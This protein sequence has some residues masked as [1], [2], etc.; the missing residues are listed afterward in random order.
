MPPKALAGP[1]GYVYGRRRR[2]VKR[3]N[4]LPIRSMGR[5]IKF[6]QR[7]FNFT[8]C[9]DKEFLYVYPDGA[10]GIDLGKAYK[11]QLN[12]LPNYDEFTKLFDYYRIKCV[13]MKF[14]PVT[15]QTMVNGPN[16]DTNSNWCPIVYTCI[17]TN[18]NNTPIDETEILQEKTCK[19]FP[20]T[21]F[22]TFKIYPKSQTPVYRDGISN[23][24]SS[25]KTNTWIDTDNADVPYYGFKVYVAANGNYATT[26]TVR[27]ICKYYLQVKDPK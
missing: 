24:Y 18:D 5:L 15:V 23:A 11:F 27:V 3:V 26:F 25:S 21:S 13:V 1:K 17:D 22:K 9:C 14:I 10:P 7:V 2:R 12:D 19:F 16:S 6:K 8:R 20:M 4:P